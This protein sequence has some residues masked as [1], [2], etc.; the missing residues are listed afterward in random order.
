LTG[1]THESRQVTQATINRLNVGNFKQFQKSEKIKQVALMAIAVQSDP[2]D[3]QELKSIFQAL[4]RDGNGSI[5]LE[6]LQHGLG[7][8]ENGD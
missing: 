7:D 3:I 5:S 8:R 4:D 6:E 1:H 2:N